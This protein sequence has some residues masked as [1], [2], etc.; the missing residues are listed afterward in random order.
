MTQMFHK[1]K[2]T[3]GVLLVKNVSNIYNYQIKILAIIWFSAVVPKQVSTLHDVTHWFVSC[4]FEA[5]SLQF[6]CRHLSKPH[7]EIIFG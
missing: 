7:Q 5:L 4:Y 6:G 1:Q 3:G 2:S